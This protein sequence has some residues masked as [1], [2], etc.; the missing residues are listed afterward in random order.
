M[1]KL[2][3]ITIL[4]MACGFLSIDF[5]FAGVIED[6]SITQ[7]LRI[8]QG[9]LSGELTAREVKILKNEQRHIRRIKKVSRF[10]G[11]LTYRESRYIEKI[12]NRASRHIFRLK[13][14]DARRYRRYISSHHHRYQ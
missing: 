9:I 8:R 1:K 2:I 10:G 4:L 14:N 6:R 11:K 3:I 13:H 7:G 12:Q 5:A